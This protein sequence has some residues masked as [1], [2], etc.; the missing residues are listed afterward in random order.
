MFL[1]YISQLFTIIYV[2]AILNKE[3]EF[4]HDIR[5]V[6]CALT[7]ESQSAWCVFE[8]EVLNVSFIEFLYFFLL[9]EEQKIEQAFRYVV[10]IVLVGLALCLHGF[11]IKKITRECVGEMH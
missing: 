8:H 10:D 6:L 1:Y 7:G 3:E 11:G 9:L 5:Y 4:R 2:S